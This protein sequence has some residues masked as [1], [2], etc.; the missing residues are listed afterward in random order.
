MLETALDQPARDREAFVRGA[1]QS[2]PA[3][4][5]EVLS[6]LAAHRPEDA[7]TTT[8]SAPTPLTE[9]PGTVVGRYRLLQQIGDGGFGVVFLAEQRE[10]IHRKVALKVIK[11][12]MDTRQVVARFEAERQ[13]LGLMDHPHIARV[14]DGGA[15]D[16]GRPFFVMEYVQGDPITDFANAHRLSVRERLA[17]IMQCCQA[18]Q[19]AH[20][21]GIIHRDIKPRNVLVSVV[22]GRPFAKVIDFG[23]AKATAARL[24]ERTLFTEHQ[25]LIGTPQYMSP[26][27]AEGSPDIDT[28]TD[29]YALGVLLYELLTGDTPFDAKRLRSAAH[30][31]MQRIIREEEP[32]PP[33]LR[34]MKRLATEPVPVGVASHQAG[35]TPAGVE[36]SSPL[37]PSGPPPL[38]ASVASSPLVKSIRGELDWIALKAL[39]KDRTRRYETPSD[40]AEDLDRHMKGEPVFAAPPSWG[41]R[42]AKFVRRNRTNVVA[43]SGVMMAMLIG[44]GVAT[45]QWN[46]ARAQRDRAE[47]EVAKLDKSSKLATDYLTKV[48]N[49]LTG[50]V[51]RGKTGPTLR[52]DATLD[53]SGTD[54]WAGVGEAALRSIRENRR[55]SQSL[56]DER[57]QL[58][59]LKEEADRAREDAEWSAYSANIAAAQLATG[60]G[61]PQSARQRLAQCAEDRRGFEWRYLSYQTACNATSNFRATTGRIQ[62][63]S[64]SEDGSLLEVWDD[65]GTLHRWRALDSGS[66]WTHLGS[67]YVESSS[68]PRE[69]FAW[70]WG[71]KLMISQPRDPARLPETA[72]VSVYFPFLD[73]TAEN[74]TACLDVDGATVRC[75][76]PRNDA[77]PL[78]FTFSSYVLDHKVSPDQSI[79]VCSTDDGAVHIINRSQNVVI[80]SLRPDPYAHIAVGP[81]GSH[82]TLTRS[83]R[84]VQLRLELWNVATSSLIADLSCADDGVKFL[85]NDRLVV[86][87]YYSNELAVLDYLSGAEIYRLQRRQD[88]ESPAWDADSNNRFIAF[89]QKPGVIALCRSEDG[90]QLARLLGPEDY[91]RAVR[92]SPDAKWVSAGTANGRIY[93]WNTKTSLQP[94]APTMLIRWVDSDLFSD[95]DFRSRLWATLVEA[96]TDGARRPHAAHPPE[97]EDQSA[98][99]RARAAVIGELERYS[100]VESKELFNIE[101]PSNYSSPGYLHRE[102]RHGPSLLLLHSKLDEY[103][104]TL[105]VFPK[106]AGGDVYARRLAMEGVF[107][108]T[109]SADGTRVFAACSDGTL[110]VLSTMLGTELLRIPVEEGTLLGVALV[111]NSDSLFVRSVSGIYYIATSPNETALAAT[112]GQLIQRNLQSD[113]GRANWTQ[114]LADLLP[115]R[116]DGPFATVMRAACDLSGAR[117]PDVND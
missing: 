60:A 56:R 36:S 77:G 55:L 103:G 86:G 37:H 17:L 7:E 97:I 91:V 93:C 88:C 52:E 107:D 26:E 10:P 104:G 5:A 27:Q 24:T 65:A 30:A 99:Q 20:H 84:G 39:E 44:G 22:D 46:E 47:R 73:V 15:T 8:I 116:E 43:T 45:W 79:L 40:L 13:A 106:G 33:S 3:L 67:Q 70:D 109:F 42:L 83:I 87:N 25:Q 89:E 59:V 71:A 85:N 29:V 11:L 75:S 19:H 16:S 72:N 115:H 92:I 57:N 31:E 94:S 110:R 58:Q 105:C 14:F 112:T 113:G 114:G 80:G 53:D 81:N 76:A 74:A 82:A 64:F 51:L 102:S 28:R 49:E 50:S 54:N 100:V 78:A 48:M 69:Y 90:R 108:A 21:K 117:R 63:M 18:V 95:L 12:G 66:E 96:C 111:G 4:L 62:D 38:R 98:L 32:P 2:D 9:K 68:P 101:Y 61:D 35:V 23:I 34:L 1:C 6:L 41:Y